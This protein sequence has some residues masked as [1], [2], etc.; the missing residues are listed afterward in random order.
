M[1]LSR[2]IIY[3]ENYPLPP[4]D[5]P[6]IKEVPLDDWWTIGGQKLWLEEIIQSDVCDK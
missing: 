6:T 2:S 3:D 1:K 5:I 4:E